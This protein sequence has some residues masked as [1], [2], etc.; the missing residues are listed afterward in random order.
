MEYCHGIKNLKVA[1][2]EIVDS[3]AP[4]CTARIPEISSIRSIEYDGNDRM[5]IRKA[6]GV[7]S[8]LAVP[9]TGLVVP[10]NMRLVESFEPTSIINVSGLT[11]KRRSDRQYQKFF[12]CPDDSC[13][14]SFNDEDELNTHVASSTHTNRESRTSSN[15]SARI[16]LFDK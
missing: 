13:I 1:T 7:G 8:G 3:T 4:L 6:S 2:A 16:L 15:D 5:V 14:E 9:F 10:I 11:S 12:F